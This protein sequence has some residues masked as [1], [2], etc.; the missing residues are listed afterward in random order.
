MI[1][2]CLKIGR[3]DAFVAYVPNL[4]STPSANTTVRWLDKISP[5]IADDP[6]FIHDA[7]GE[8]TL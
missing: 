6:L 7:R 1:Q 8:F 5:W 4:T 2:M 3:E